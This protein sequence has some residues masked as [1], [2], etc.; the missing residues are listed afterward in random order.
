MSGNDS[1][2]LL[3]ADVEKHIGLL[4]ELRNELEEA[5]EHDVEILGKTR[6][7]AAMA[8]SIIESYYT[9]C[10]T[11]FFRISQFFENNLSDNRTQW[12]SA[13]TTRCTLRPSPKH[14]TASFALI[15]R[16]IRR[17]S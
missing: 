5:I 11:V 14:R 8:A 13:I 9:C 6:R 12:R 7:T 10:E 17:S 1:A 15:R 16:K 3:A 2:N 4:E